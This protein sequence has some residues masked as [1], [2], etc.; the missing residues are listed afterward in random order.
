MEHPPSSDKSDYCRQK[1]SLRLKRFPISQTAEER[2]AAGEGSALPASFLSD[3]GG[4]GLNQVS[5]SYFSFVRHAARCNQTPSGLLVPDGLVLGSG[6]SG[7]A[8]R[9]GRRI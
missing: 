1:F 9:P 3:A 5:G 6:N 4:L 8:L 7:R 2:S